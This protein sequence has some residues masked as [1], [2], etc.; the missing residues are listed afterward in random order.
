MDFNFEKDILL[1]NDRA[2]LRPL[3]LP[4]FDDL[5]AIAL[6]DKTLLQYSPTQI[7]SE[8]LLKQY[9]DNALE[10]RDNKNRYPFIIF[11]KQLNSYAGSTSFL[12]I[13]NKDQR[14][15]IGATWLGRQFQQTGLNRNCKYLLLNY[16]FEQLEFERL[17]F[18]I[19]ERNKP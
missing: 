6:Q 14:I 16:V 1:E 8:Q 4:D 13:S 18:K 12:N 5:I 15:E 3:A 10:E 11:D 17:E 7:H 2:K 19:D 9:I